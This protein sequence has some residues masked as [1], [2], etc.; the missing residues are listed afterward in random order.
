MVVV[1][2]EEMVVVVEVAVVVVEEMVLEVEMGVVVEVEKTVEIRP[3][4]T[5]GSSS[6]RVH[7]ATFLHFF[8]KLFRRISIFGCCSI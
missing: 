7:E 1:V 5:A 4:R 3:P 2:E 8:R 6:S